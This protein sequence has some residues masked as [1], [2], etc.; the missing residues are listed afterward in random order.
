MGSVSDGYHTLEEL[1]AHRC[2]L[3]MAL[4]QAWPEYAWVS[5]L[6]DDGSGIDGWFV[7]GMNLPTGPITYHLPM[8]MW[9]LVDKLECP[10]LELAPKF[11]G[12][13]SRD[14]LDRLHA[15]IVRDVLVPASVSLDVQ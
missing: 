4:M 13:T 15:W 5:K 9:P 14:V 2:K 11:D 6:H 1:Y 8:D 10:I 3:F 7:A 12:H